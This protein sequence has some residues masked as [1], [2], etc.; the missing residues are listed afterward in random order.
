MRNLPN[1]PS[2]FPL[3]ADNDSSSSTRPNGNQRKMEN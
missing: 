2:T 3:D 1:D